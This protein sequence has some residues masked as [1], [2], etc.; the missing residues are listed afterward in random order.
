MSALPL[1]VASFSLQGPEASKV[2]V[3]IHADVG[4]EYTA[5]RRMSLG[6]TITDRDGRLVDSHGGD[7][8]LAPAAPGVPSPLQYVIGASVPPGDYTLKLAAADGDRA[9]SIEHSFHAGLL[10]AGPLRVSELIV[11]GPVDP[12]AALQPTV[13][14]T[15]SYGSLQGYLEAYGASAASAQ[16]KYEI[17]ADE[18][19]PPILSADVRPRPAGEGRVL[20]TQ[21]LPVRALPAGKYLLR[22][23]ISAGERP[24]RTLT[25][26]FELS[27][28]PVLMTSANGFS[29]DAPSTDGELFLPVEDR[30]FEAPFRREEALNDATLEPFRSKVPQALRA[31]FD[32]GVAQLAA[33][34]Y[35]HAELSFKQA[36]QPDVDSTPGLAYLAV[37][38]AASGHD[39]EAANAWQTALVDG[40]DLPQ[41]YQ[42][43]SEA[44][45]R[46]HALGE[47]RSVLEE[48]IGRWPMDVRFMRPLA[49]VYASFGKGREAVRTLDR[50][51]AA[52][53]VDPETLALGLEWIYQIHA[54]GGVV[55]NRSED[56]KIARRYADAYAKAN[57]PR[58]QLVKQWLDFLVNEK[59]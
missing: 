27:P 34:D 37:A 2:Q 39:A 51:I 18:S 9:G 8:R 29:P 47:A 36:I 56:L 23:V 32:K 54:A 1:R 40:N 15:I 7:V 10:D 53:H 43:L 28:P 17:A 5:A 59:R 30:A 14:Y 22:A 46:T 26:A 3:L 31:A 13:G 52:A 20:F 19:S 42:W 12:A 44:L 33:G 4:A 58:Q 35:V 55:Q 16:V 25:R 38:F 41:I 6:Y 50:Y 24:I 48:A 21:V 57:G 45:L 11:G 49:F